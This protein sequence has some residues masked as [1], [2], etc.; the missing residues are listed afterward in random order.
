MPVTVSLFWGT[1]TGY[2]TQVEGGL[3]LKDAFHFCPSSFWYEEMEAA[4]AGALRIFMGTGKGMI[5]S[6]L[7]GEKGGAY[8]VYPDFGIWRKIFSK[9]HDE[10]KSF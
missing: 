8:Y 7:R 10:I 5:V 2:K 6:G 9:F 4:A 3:F 1:V